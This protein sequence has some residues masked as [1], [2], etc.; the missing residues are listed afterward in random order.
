M[1]LGFSICLAYENLGLASP[2][3]T[4]FYLAWHKMH[5]L[6]HTFIQY[7][8]FDERYYILHFLFDWRIATSEI[9]YL[10]VA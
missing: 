9:Y 1:S 8:I 7:V 10:W 6:K 5:I 4:W 3:I 2:K